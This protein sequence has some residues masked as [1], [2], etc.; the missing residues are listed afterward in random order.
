MSAYLGTSAHRIMQI[1]GALRSPM[2]IIALAKAINM[3]ASNIYRYV[4]WLEASDIVRKIGHVHGAWNKPQNV[5]QSTMRFTRTETTSATML[6]I[7]PC[8]TERL[9]RRP[10]TTSDPP[11]T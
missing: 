2:T 7:C 9:R 4:Y 10:C 11:T 3:D 5:Y 1:I 6:G 8:S